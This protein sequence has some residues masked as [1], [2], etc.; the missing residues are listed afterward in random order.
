[1]FNSSKIPSSKKSREKL[2]KQMQVL[3]STWN[4]TQMHEYVMCKNEKY[5]CTYIGFNAILDKFNHNKSEDKDYSNGR[6]EFEA[7]DRPERLKKAFDLVAI[8]CRHPRSN[9]KTMQSIQVFLKCYMDVI[10]EYDKDNSKEYK[11]NLLKAFRVGLFNLERRIQ[12]KKRAIRS[13]Q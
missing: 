5:I 11:K 1:M 6:R 2:F 8:M 4:L 12:E 3:V 10:T 9:V 13:G 7:T